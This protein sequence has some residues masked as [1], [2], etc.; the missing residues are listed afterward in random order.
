MSE[1]IQLS[2][3]IC[4]PRRTAELAIGHSGVMKVLAM[5]INVRQYV[6]RREEEYSEEW[7]PC[8][9]GVESVVGEPTVNE[10]NGQELPDLAEA[11]EIYNAGVAEAQKGERR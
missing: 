8:G 5:G 9:E 4:V 11:M 1:S 10:I 7:Q 6:D 3:N 2:S